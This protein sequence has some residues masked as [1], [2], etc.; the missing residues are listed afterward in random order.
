MRLFEQF[1]FGELDQL[2]RPIADELFP[3]RPKWAVASISDFD[4][5]FFAGLAIATSPKKIVEV[6]VAS[7]WGS[8]LLLRALSKDRNLDFQYYGVDIS[9]RFFYDSAYATGQAVEAVVP[10]LK[11]RY[12]LITGHSIAEV[13]ERI[14]TGVDF[15]FIDAHHMHP[16]ATLDLLS[17]LPFLKPTSWVALHDLSLCRKEDQEHRNRGPKYLFEGWEKDKAHSVQIPTMAGAIRIGDRTEDHLPLLLDI[18]YTPWELPVEQRYISAVTSLISKN[19]GD[20]WGRK[21][22]RAAEVG[23]YLANKMHSHDIDALTAEIARLRA[24]ASAR[25]RGV[26]GRI[27]RMLGG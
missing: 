25:V 6:G 26:F 23:N 18:L 14:G 13:S 22:S 2:G 21:F 4:A 19:Y 3:T 17:V 1:S 24:T 5:S 16:W 15:A 12:Q 11:S 9:E 20:E 27:T 8:A 7:G 10:D